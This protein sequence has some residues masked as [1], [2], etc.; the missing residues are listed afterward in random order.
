MKTY[1]KYYTFLI[2]LLLF[3]NISNGL[4][5]SVTVYQRNLTPIQLDIS[6][7][8]S[9]ELRTNLLKIKLFGM[10]AEEI[11]YFRLSHP[12]RLVI[13]FLGLLTES[14]HDLNFI[15]SG[16]KSIRV[17][18]HPNKVRVVIDLRVGFEDVLLFREK[19]GVVKIVLID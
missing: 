10:G 4:E 18:K 15:T 11:T 7:Q 12:N 19:N 2:L 5:K 13:D 6:R 9:P 14:S 17:G 16:I 8:R 3:P 1:I